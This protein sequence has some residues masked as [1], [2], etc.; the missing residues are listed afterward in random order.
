[1]LSNRRVVSIRPLLIFLAALA[2]TVPAAAQSGRETILLDD[3][4]RFALGHAADP[5]KDFDFGAA[6][7]YASANGWGGAVRTGFDDGAWRTVDLPHDWAVEL[8]FV[9]SPFSLRLM[10]HGFKPLARIF[11]ETSIGWY[12]R[13]FTVPKGDEG[14]RFRIDFEGAFRDC[15]VWLN[16]ILLGRHEGGYD[17][18]CFDATDLV[19]RGG[20]NVLVVRV[21]AT[22][23]E[24]WFYEGAGLYRHVRLTK[25]AP[26]HIAV[27]GTYVTA[28][29]EGNAATLTIETEIA[30]DSAAAAKIGLKSAILDP[31]GK[32]AGE[33][34]EAARAVGPFQTAVIRQSLRLP[35]P[36]LWTLEK[37]SLYTLASTVLLEGRPLAPDTNPRSSAAESEP[38]S[39][40]GAPTAVD[41]LRTRFGVRS[42]RFDKDKGFF[43]N[44]TRV[45]IQG[46]CNHQ[47]HA[48]VGAALPD[49][50]QYFRV[51]K[52]KE[53]G[54]NAYRTSHNPPTTELLDACDELGMLVMDETRLFSS[55]AGAL[56]QLRRMVR[57][58]RNHPSIILWSIGNE[59]GVQAAP[60]GRRIAETM[61][62]AVK[63][64]DTT[65]PTTY[66]S[67]SGAFEGINQAVDVR[68][69]NYHLGEIDAYHAAHPDQPLY[70]SE[71][72][73][74]LTTRGEY[75]DDKTR[76]YMASYDKSCPRWGELAREWMIFYT[77]RP[78]LAGAFVWTGFD[79]RGEPTPYVWPCISSHFGIL[80]TCGFPK[81]LFWYYKSWWT[82]EPVLHIFPHWNWKG[83]EGQAIEVWAYSNMDEVRLT[84]N[85]KDLGTKKIPRFGRAEWSVPYE[86]GRL[87]AVGFRNGKEA[88]REA[89]ETTGDSAR[90]TLAADR[91]AISADGRDLS[92]V[93]VGALDSKGRPMPIAADE[94]FF[95]LSGPGRII[96]VGN[97]N[98]SSH[99]PDVFLPGPPAKA[100]GKAV[101]PQWK[102]RLF[103][104]LAQVLVQA[105]RSAG[106]MTLRAS[107]PGLAPT[108]LN[109]RTANSYH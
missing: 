34:I 2:F 85:G 36:L 93:T 79:Y 86:P 16:G 43:L 67:N 50:L 15:H 99:E 47:D 105:G 58:D 33:I 24:G 9:Q 32:P 71:I 25:T 30:N 45:Q 96:G 38:R 49:R 19:N 3:G 48:G 44:G 23:N 68:G 90:L 26:V 1:M 92:I 107:T 102:R 18:F 66:A 4:W 21:D 22:H 100:G 106:T 17:P 62:R 91:A 78:W 54:V 11:P 46:V 89:V 27:W 73:S 94:V 65:R 69:F 31:S 60:V 29:V 28:Q 75:A 35:A 8:P 103:N 42:I 97:G 64:L 13:H 37:P 101:P 77:A 7:S 98:P 63:A 81:D 109:I 55:S 6:Y 74:T 12:R 95:D 80:D 59:E 61:V 104:G 56:D 5:A 70:G 52:L 87:E 82:N 88:L 83:R 108:V 51:T 14:R 76:G 40:P 53:M 10:D 39:K 41:T 57:R 72:A 20:E 84:L